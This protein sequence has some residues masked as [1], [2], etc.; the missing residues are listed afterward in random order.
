[1]LINII[2]P[3]TG[4]YITVSKIAKHKS[5]AKQSAKNEI[6]TKQNTDKNNITL[7]NN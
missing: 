6:A 5:L 1:M 2:K 3:Q 7:N 4:I